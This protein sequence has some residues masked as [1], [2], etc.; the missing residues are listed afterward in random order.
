MLGVVAYTY[1]L[2]IGLYLF[3]YCILKEL[4]YFDHAYSLLLWTTRL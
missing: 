1:E 3:I 2:R 4:Y